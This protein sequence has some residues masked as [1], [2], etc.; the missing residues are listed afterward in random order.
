MITVFL[1]EA[2]K[3]KTRTRYRNIFEAVSRLTLLGVEN[4]TLIEVDSR[5]RERIVDSNNLPSELKL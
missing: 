2:N 1:K 5:G 3:P 4:Y